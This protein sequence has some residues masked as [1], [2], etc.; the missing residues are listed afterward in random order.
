MLLDGRDAQAVE[1]AAQRLAAGELVSLT[2]PLAAAATEH[3][4]SSREDAPSAEGAKKFN[5][6]AG[7]SS[8]EQVRSDEKKDIDGSFKKEKKR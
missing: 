5:E 1:Q 8:G 7:D 4:E 3:S 2:P 6:R